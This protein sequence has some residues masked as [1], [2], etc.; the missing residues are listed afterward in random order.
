MKK[1]LV[2]VLLGLAAW[3]AWKHYPELLHR[4]PSHEAV[5]ENRSGRAIE[6]LRL[7]IGG[8][9]FVKEVLGSGE[10]ATFPFRVSRD[11][12]FRL[13]WDWRD[14]Q[15]E[16][17]WRGGFVPRGPLVQRHVITIEPSGG[18]IYRAEQTAAAP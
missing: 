3:Q 12:S 4:A 2:L 11:A 14:A 10:T 5:V 7:N 6:R 16:M 17:S 1:L 9:T 8:R 15:G 18:V 13:T